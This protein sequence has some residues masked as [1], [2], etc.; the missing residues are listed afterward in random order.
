MTAATQEL[1]PCA[2]GERRA[3]PGVAAWHPAVVD[4]DLRPLEHADLA[5]LHTWLN[6]PEVVRWWE[7]NDV[8]WEAVVRDY[9]PGSDERT[10][11]W[12][13]LVEGDPVGWIQCYAIA[14]YAE[15]GEVRHWR[16]LGIEPTAAGIDYL[17]GE[18]TRR[19]QGVGTAMIRAFVAEVV[20]GRHPGWTQ[21][22]ASPLAANT[23]SLRALAK[24]GFVPGGT[25]VD[26]HGPAQLMVRERATADREPPTDG[27]AR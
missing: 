24:A 15:E 7:G 26:E 9:G 10:E 16:A 11:H 23:A 5:L 13:A 21:V 6:D 19:G 14:D 2:A 1:A 17:V 22:A 20:F 12:L 18:P 3:V 4:I 8:S 25:F 27:S